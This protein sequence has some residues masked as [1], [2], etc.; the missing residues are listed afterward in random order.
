VVAKAQAVASAMSE[1]CEVRRIVVFLEKASGRGQ[2]KCPAPMRQMP[3]RALTME[4]M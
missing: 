4:S 1:V 3:L 2:S